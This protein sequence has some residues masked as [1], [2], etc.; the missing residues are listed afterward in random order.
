MPG[1]LFFIE[2]VELPSS[3]E[4]GER[5]AFAELSLESVA[6]FPVE[7]LLWG[8]FYTEGASFILLFATH[9]ERLKQAGF[10]D[11]ETYAWVL[12]DFARLFGAH[13]ERDTFVCLETGATKNGYYFPA[14]SRIPEQIV[15]HPREESDTS[16]VLEELRQL[17]SSGD[18]E[19][20][21]VSLVAA[22]A[23]LNEHHLPVFRHDPAD[24]EQT[25]DIGPSSLTAICPSEEELWRA[26]IRSPAFKKSERSARRTGALLTRI[27]GWA[28]AFGL[29]L[30]MLEL[31]LFGGKVW[32]GT[33]NQRIESRHTEVRTVQDKQSLL[34][35]L[36]QVAQ[37]ELRPIAILEALNEKR[38]DDIYFTTTVTEGQNQI[39][40]D[41]VAGT[42]NALNR[43]T[44]QLDDSERFELLGSPATLIRSGETTFT[45]RLAYIPPD[46]PA[47]DH[48]RATA[49]PEVAKESN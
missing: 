24:P 48:E 31:A 19:P 45:A 7:Q 47:D 23:E 36:E 10:K 27:T 22:S 46:R 43:Y 26:D 14:D 35:K 20:A 21:T 3:L 42:V 12:P 13:F 2:P 39:M 30:L 11:S 41:G 16:G 6:P 40:I 17:V 9:R 49:D 15:A 8:Y 1:F 37:N 33:L 29:V 5:D 4:P 44:E 34:N 18:G 38:P 25:E 28:C 32:L